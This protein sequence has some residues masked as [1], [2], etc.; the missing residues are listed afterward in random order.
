M[1]RPSEV[2]FILQFKLYTAVNIHSVMI[3]GLD[4]KLQDS[5]GRKPALQNLHGTS[6][7]EVSDSL[8]Q[9]RPPVVL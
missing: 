3:S 6:Y 1:Q 8:G 5:H 2:V 4:S 9:A 7:F